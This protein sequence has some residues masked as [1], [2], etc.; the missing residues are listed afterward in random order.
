MA[1]R[2]RRGG[3]GC[4]GVFGGGRGGRHRRR[5]H[6]LRR[7]ARVGGA[8]RS[9]AAAGRGDDAFRDRPSER[10]EGRVVGA[11]AGQQ[12]LAVEVP[13]DDSPT[14]ALRRRAGAAGARAR[15]LARRWEAK[16]CASSCALSQ[17]ASSRR[18]AITQARPLL[19]S[20]P[21]HLAGG[22]ARGRG[23]GAGEHR[24]AR[25]CFLFGLA[26]ERVGRV[27][28]SHDRGTPWQSQGGA[29]WAMV[30]CRSSFPLSVVA[31]S[32]RWSEGRASH[33][34]AAGAR[35]RAPTAAADGRSSFVL[36]A[37][38]TKPCLRSLSRHSSSTT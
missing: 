36:P 35:A 13:A 1:G 27:S 33:N 11:R 18:H 7:R 20:S 15:S 31:P 8:G 32:G 34:G 9:R 22:H 25:V 29:F 4:E 6:H 30:V 37:I 3:G 2:P 14:L 5:A 28:A 19:L 26:K 23:R 12:M 16:Q 17:R 38:R 24:A 10:P 21:A